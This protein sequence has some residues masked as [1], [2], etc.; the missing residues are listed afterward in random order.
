MSW[1]Y[2]IVCYRNDE[3]FGLHEVHYDEAG[4]PWG[5]TENP[6]G[7][8]CAVDEGPA[9]VLDSLKLALADAT[10]RPVLDV[11][12]IWPGKAPA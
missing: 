6:A 5:M 11:P 4:L 2:R 9:G 10:S 1:S 3:G 12:E 7:F 8:A